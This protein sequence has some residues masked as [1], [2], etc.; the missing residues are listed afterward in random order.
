MPRLLCLCLFFKV[1]GVIII[2]YK[3]NQTQNS[4][5]K[6]RQRSRPEPEKTGGSEGADVTGSE[7]PLAAHCGGPGPQ[8]VRQF[9]RDVPGPGGGRCAPAGGVRRAFGLAAEGAVTA[10]S[11]LLSE[12]QASGGQPLLEAR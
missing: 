8:G 10:G 5:I 4:N 6:S 2:L 3:L 12:Q 7:D 1:V 9:V 11:L